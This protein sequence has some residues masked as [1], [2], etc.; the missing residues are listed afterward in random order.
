VTQLRNNNPT[1]NRAHRI[2]DEVRAGIWHSKEAVAW[3]LSV[4]G[5]P[6]NV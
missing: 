5:E 3:A 4:L 2:L 1:K 6:V